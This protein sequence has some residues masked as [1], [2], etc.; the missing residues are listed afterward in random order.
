MSLGPTFLK[1][2]QLF[3]TRTD[4]LPAEVT[5]EL[6]RGGETAQCRRPPHQCGDADRAR[7]DQEHDERVHAPFPRS[8]GGTVGDARGAGGMRTPTAV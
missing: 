3:S 7:R 1:I 8:R 5:E 4:I 2:G 6:S